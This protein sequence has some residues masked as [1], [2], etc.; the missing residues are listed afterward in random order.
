MQTAIRSAWKEA[1]CQGVICLPWRWKMS[2]G[3]S[4]RN[5]PTT[6]RWQKGMLTKLL[7]W[8]LWQSSWWTRGK[9]MRHWWLSGNLL[10]L[11][12]L[13]ILKLHFS[14]DPMENTWQRKVTYY[15]CQQHILTTIQFLCM[16]SANSE[17]MK[18]VGHGK[19][20]FTSN[21]TLASLLA[22]LAVTSNV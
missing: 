19:T 1:P 22:Y 7:W 20:P 18:R 13:P 21:A 4:L 17:E 5:S 16:G 8:V 9:K 3:S 6:R 15:I 2:T 11:C 14:R 10:K 12:G